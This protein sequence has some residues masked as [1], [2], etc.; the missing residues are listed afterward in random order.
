M[1]FLI[2]FN[3]LPYVLG[4]SQSIIIY[5]NVENSGETAY[6]A[7]IRISL[8]DSEVLFTKTPSNCKLDETAPNSNIMECDLNNG[9]P[10]FNGDKT[11]IRIGIDTTK[12]D[13]TE[14]IIKAKVYSTGD[15]L[16]E[17]DNTAESVIPLKEFSIVEVFG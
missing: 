15:E 1:L 9:S 2:L 16:N 11:S 6:L 14:L 3:S 10:M 7:Q 4:S 8:P 17:Y 12:L 5:Y 13:G